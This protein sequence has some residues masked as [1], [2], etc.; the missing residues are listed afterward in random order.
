M[1]KTAQVRAVLSV[2]GCPDNE[3]IKKYLCKR[4]KNIFFHP[5]EEERKRKITCIVGTETRDGD[6]DDLLS[7]DGEVARGV[8]RQ[9]V[10]AEDAAEVFDVE[11][12]LNVG[13]GTSVHRSVADKSLAC[14]RR[15]ALE[16]LRGRNGGE[17]GE[18]E[19]QK[20]QLAEIAHDLIGE[21]K[22]VK[23]EEEDE[24]KFIEMC[25]C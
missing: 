10:G 1:N 19:E 15:P 12:R 25:I 2:E 20:R 16:V 24:G 8:E 23:A 5:K 13:N 6:F 17:N 4:V 3:M 18:C 14:C 22:K 7:F 21:R 11:E 9:I